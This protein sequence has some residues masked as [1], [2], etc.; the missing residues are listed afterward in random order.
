LVGEIRADLADIL[1]LQ[2]EVARSIAREIR[3]QL[4]P[5]EQVRLARTRPVDPA[6]YDAY[7][8]GSY[9]LVKAIPGLAKSIDFFNEA[10]RLDPGYADSHAG[11][12]Q[13]LSD[14]AIYGV[15]PRPP[16]VVL[17]SARAVALQALNLD[18][19]NAPAHRVLAEIR[20][21]Y[22]WDLGGAVVEYR[23]A[24][25][26]NPN[27]MLSHLR[28]A[29]CLSRMERHREALAEVELGRRLDPISPMINGFHAMVLFRARRFDD[30]IGAARQALELDPAFVNA[31]WWQGMSY[32]GKRHYTEA[33]DC[34][35][36]AV[37]MSDRL[38]FRALRAHVYGLAGERPKAIQ[39]IEELTE[40][41][42][43]KRKYVSPV[44]FAVVHA[45]LGDAN[46]A[47]HRLEEAYQERSP[48]IH[49][50]TFM[51]FDRIRSDARYSGLV[52]RVGLPA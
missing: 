15:D 37:R 20:K 35:T 49:E 45:G 36:K 40:E 7:L 43:A 33:V 28:Y 9:F 26:L 12:A 22:D 30:A 17:P 24:L 18:E 42:A 46:P 50:L 3:I 48:R 52:R 21:G 8:K 14:A 38:L 39:A 32:A 16:N 2:S 31:L 6:A 34:L 27:Q 5:E 4:T 11:L 29:D 1:S 25:Q 23:R 51:Y 19:S 13:A 44:D 10:I 47:F 41:E